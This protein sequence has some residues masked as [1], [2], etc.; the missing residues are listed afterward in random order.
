MKTASRDELMR[1]EVDG[2]SD[3][4]R[5]K[6]RGV[7]IATGRGAINGCSWGH[8]EIRSRDED[9]EWWFDTNKDTRL[10]LTCDKQGSL[11]TLMRHV[12]RPWRGCET[13][14][15]SHKAT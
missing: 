7:A 14:D 10:L 15:T 12:I 8:N 13:G 6:L 11:V 9:D 1:C 3:S 2:Y 4:S 5:M